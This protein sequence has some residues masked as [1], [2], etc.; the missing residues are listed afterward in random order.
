MQVGPGRR[1]RQGRADLG[2]ALH[3]HAG[4][5][6][7]VPAGR[8]ALRR[9]PVATRPSPGSR[10]SSRSPATRP[11]CT[12][13][14]TTCS[15]ACGI[16][17]TEEGR[18]QGSPGVAVRRLQSRPRRGG[19]STSRWARAPRRPSSTTTPSCTG[20]RRKLAVVPVNGYTTE[21]SRSSSAPSASA[22]T[23]AAIGEAGRRQHP[24][25]PDDG[26]YPAGR[27]PAVARRRRPAVHR[28]AARGAGRATWPTL[29]R[30]RLRCRSVE[31]AG[32][33]RAARLEMATPRL[34]SRSGFRSSPLVR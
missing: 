24:I 18:R 19:C 11:T 33:R 26:G 32:S 27:H 16:D 2:R 7:D 13:S 3:R 8:P 34:P 22:S 31:R 21:G 4:L 25:R 17:A 1:P 9:R 28:L 10:A 30:P 14:A 5:R 15:S 12:R 20:R 29:R 6:R 23:R